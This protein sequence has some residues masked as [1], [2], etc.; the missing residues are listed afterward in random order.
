M[1][2]RYKGSEIMGL[3]LLVK[4]Q[5]SDLRIQTWWYYEILKPWFMGI[6]EERTDET[7]VAVE[8]KMEC[9]CLLT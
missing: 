7:D 4:H 8:T 2:S 3:V 6:T 9:C 5:W 1:K